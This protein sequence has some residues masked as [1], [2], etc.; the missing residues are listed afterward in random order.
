MANT[1]VGCLQEQRG[2]SQWLVPG[3]AIDGWGFGW[4]GYTCVTGTKKFRSELR[5]WLKALQGILMMTC[6]HLGVPA[7]TRPPHRLR[8]QGSRHTRT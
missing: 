6:Y 4:A 2:W 3:Q 8:R 1:S 7:A 5:C